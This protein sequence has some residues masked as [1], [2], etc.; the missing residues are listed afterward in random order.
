MLPADVTPWLYPPN[1]PV[2]ERLVWRTSVLTAYQGDE[3]RARV[4][5]YPRRSFEY[6]VMLQGRDRREAENRLQT[7]QGGRYGIPVWMDSLPL[8]SAVSAGVST[9]A[10]DTSTRDY[11]AGGR[12]LLWQSPQVFEVANISSVT[13][14]TIGLATPLTTGW[15]AGTRVAPIRLAYLPPDFRLTRYTGDASTATVQ[16][17]CV[18][19]SDLGFASETPLYRSVPVLTRRP[20]WVSDISAS[21]QTLLDEIDFGIGVPI[22]DVRSAGAITVHSLSWTLADRDGIDAYRQ[23]LYARAGR[24][25]AF[26]QP[27]WQQDLRIVANIG[28]SAVSIDIERCEYSTAVA[29]DR[30]RRDLRIERL[31]GTVHYRRVTASAAISSTVERL[32]I[33][34]NLGTALAAADVAAVSFMQLSR[35]AADSAEILWRRSDWA[36]SRLNVRGLRND[37]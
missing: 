8:T 7:R 22:R 13:S 36:E 9:L 5:R 27:S 28:A 19:D 15:P 4:A 25:S 29:Q 23:W 11:A 26:W 21:Y 17:E 6:A 30:A 35:L 16:A 3:Q 10:I 37:L 18:D 14:S 31:D 1:G 2:I 32:T 33:D 12:V 20:N 34:S 24:L